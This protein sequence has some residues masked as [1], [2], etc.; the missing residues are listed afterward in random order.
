VGCGGIGPNGSVPPADG[1]VFSLET[2]WGSGGVPGFFGGFGRTRPSDLGGMEAFNF[3]INPDLLDCVGRTQDYLLEINLQDDDD[4]DNAIPFPPDGA[5]DEF[6]YNCVI[7]PVGPCAISGGGWQRVS[8]PLADFFDD[9]SF[10]FGGNG[11]LDAVSTANGGNGQLINVVIAVISNSGADATFRTDYWNFTPPPPSEVVFDDMEH[12]NPFGSG[13]FAFG[14]SVGGGGIGP[15]FVDLPPAFGGAASLETGWGGGGP[16]FFGGFG[17]TNPVDLFATRYFNFWINPDGIDGIGRPQDYLLEIN[18]QEDDNGDGAI[19][20]P[21]DDEFQ[22]NCVISAS[23]P[24]A[25]SG[26]GWQM[27]SIPLADFFDDNSFLFGG[28]GVLD[29][30]PVSRGGNGGLINVVDAVISN[31]GADATFRTDYWA[32][33][34][35]PLDGDGDRVP[36]V[37]DNCPAV[38]NPDQADNDGDGRGDACDGDDDDDG[39]GDRDD[40]CP[41]DANADQADADG[42]G[43]GDVCDPDDD[44]DGVEDG[45][46]A[47]GDSDLAATVVID[48]CDSGAPNPLSADG[49]TFSDDIAAIAAGA[50]N[51]GGFVSEVT[52]LMNAAK[53]GSG[54][55]PWRCGTERGH[56]RYSR[57]AEDALPREVSQ[58]QVHTSAR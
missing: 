33:T 20:P 9:N 14:G 3:W 46:D 55:A 31:A 43:L 22:Y 21:D 54:I 49:C 27:V 25:V 42:D 13:W 47:C 29:T 26:G 7:S 6:Q 34:N 4:G 44:N 30:D 28:N 11:V 17:R 50:G 56:R 57:Y 8:I 53:K 45:N 40:N 1:G 5:D 38:D 23:G 41:L 51:H 35:E 24:C 19:S 32:F 36:D 2:G 37:L 15:N 48:G 58:S 18:L 16:G 10:H 39:V 52:H 12:G